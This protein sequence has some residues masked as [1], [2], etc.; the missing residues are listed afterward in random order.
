MYQTVQMYKC[1]TIY[2][3]ILALVG[4]LGSFQFGAFMNKVVV[5]TFLCM[6]FMECMHLFLLEQ[7][8]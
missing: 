7:N 1:V 6:S 3:S 4:H 2:L 8:C 5:K